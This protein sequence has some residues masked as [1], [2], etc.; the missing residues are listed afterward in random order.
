MLQPEVLRDDLPH[1]GALGFLLHSPSGPSLLHMCAC[2]V[3]CVAWTWVES[4]ATQFS[5]VHRCKLLQCWQR[6]C[7][8]C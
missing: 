4:F 2:L 6:G 1:P 5:G 8:L 3:D 7:R